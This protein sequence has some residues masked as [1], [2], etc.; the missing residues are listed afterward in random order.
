MTN[1]KCDYC[2]KPSK[3]V[4]GDIVYPHRP[5]LSHKQFYQCKPCQAYVGCHAGTSNPLGRLAN[6]ELRAAK[7]KA[8]AHFDPIWKKKIQRE[9]CKKKEARGKAYR[10]LAKQLDIKFEDCHIG[11]FDEQLCAKVVEICTPPYGAKA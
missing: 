9:R 7:S 10:W 1:V 4:T 5:D 8:H 6:A 2:G 11:M 3:L